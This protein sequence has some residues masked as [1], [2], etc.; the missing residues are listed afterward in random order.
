MRGRAGAAAPHFY[1]LILYM[2]YNNSDQ[3]FNSTD[4]IQPDRVDELND[5]ILGRSFANKPVKPVFDPRSVSTKY[6]LFPIL[7]N[8]PE[9]YL[10]DK[11]A[12]GENVEI[13]TDLYGRNERSQ[14]YDSGSLFRPSLESDM[15]K[16]M[17]NRRRVTDTERALLFTRPTIETFVHPN[18]ISTEVGNDIFHNHTRTQ[19]RGS[20]S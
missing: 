3:R 17:N 14:K 5:R 7:D 1:I 6:V 20:R 4:S 19:L 9:I 16:S 10:E 8:R 15:Y 13:E 18:L 2:D 12:V 11:V